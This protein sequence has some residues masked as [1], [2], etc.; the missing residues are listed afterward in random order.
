MNG[1]FSKEDFKL[2][3][4]VILITLSIVSSVIIVTVVWNVLTVE[5]SSSIGILDEY[6]GVENITREMRVNDYFNGTVKIKNREGQSYLYR[7]YIKA[8]DLSTVTNSSTPASINVYNF[9]YFDACLSNSQTRN[10][11]VQVQLTV[12]QNN[13]K[14]IFE[15][16]KFNYRGQVFS[17]SGQWDHVWVNVTS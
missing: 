9:T 15:L 17:Y 2:Y 1:E 10:F 8:G 6:G 11:Q 5:R 16:W 14:L 13:T 12:I 7:V 3:L 4:I